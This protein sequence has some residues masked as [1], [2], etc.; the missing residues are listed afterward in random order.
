MEFQFLPQRAYSRRKHIIHQF[1]RHYRYIFNSFN[2]AVINK[3]AF[4]HIEM[5]CRLVTVV[6]ATDA[7]IGV[8]SPIL[9]PTISHHLRSTDRIHDITV[10]CHKLI[11]HIAADQVLFRGLHGIINTRLRC[12]LLNTD[13]D[14]ICTHFLQGGGHH[15]G[16]RIADHNNTNNRTNSNNNAQHGK[17]RTHFVCAQSGNGQ[18]NVL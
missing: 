8:L 11:N 1:I 17:Q 13:L 6:D 10:R 12:F 14:I 18:R 3:S 15:I 7:D 9:S 16:H 5:I 2:I 4:H